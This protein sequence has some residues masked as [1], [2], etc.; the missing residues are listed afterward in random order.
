MISA[1]SVDENIA[2][3]EGFADLLFRVSEAFDIKHIGGKS[4]GGSAF[5]LDFVC[6]FF[7]TFEF[8]VEDGDLCAAFRQSLCHA[9]AKN[10][11]SAGYHGNFSVQI[12]FCR[13][14]CLLKLL[15]FLKNS[16]DSVIYSFPCHLAIR[17]CGKNGGIFSGWSRKSRV[18]FPGGLFPLRRARPTRESSTQ[19]E[20]TST[21]AV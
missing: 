19:R 10:S 13:H 9:A 15:F 17:K 7:C 8:Q 4:D 3:A 21:D 6:N 11:A 2:G 5:F 1:S 14:F 18:I 20:M 16:N 12:Q